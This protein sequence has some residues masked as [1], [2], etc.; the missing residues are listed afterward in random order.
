M[1][2]LR[3]LRKSSS[4]TNVDRRLVTNVLL[5]FLMTPRGD[6]KRF[7]MLSLLAS[8][9]SWNDSEREKAGLQR[10]GSGNGA[11]SARGKQV[12][13]IMKNSELEKGDET[14]VRVHR[15][16]VQSL[17]LTSTPSPFPKCG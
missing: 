16:I 3:R 15:M 1:E 9:L 5:S 2:A 17:T 13:S 4:D 10:V 11:S 14:E 7:E 8:I 12:S 6:A